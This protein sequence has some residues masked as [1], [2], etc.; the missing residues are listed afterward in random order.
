MFNFNKYALKGSVSRV[1]FCYKRL[2]SQTENN[3]LKINIL[4]TQFF[5]KI[6]GQ[7]SRENSQTRHNIPKTS[8]PL[9]QKAVF[10]I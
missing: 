5:S 9:L 6:S 8:M 1:V 10:S 3:F 2:G 4:R 7:K